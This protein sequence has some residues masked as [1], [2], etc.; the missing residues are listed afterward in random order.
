MAQ[1]SLDQWRR[2]VSETP[3]HV[4]LQAGVGSMAGAVT[5]LLAHVFGERVPR[6]WLNRRRRGRFMLQPK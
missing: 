6:W 4:F 5:A 2:V 3:T 1:E